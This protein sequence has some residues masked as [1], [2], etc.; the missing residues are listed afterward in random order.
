MVCCRGR[1]AIPKPISLC[2]SDDQLNEWR[3]AVY[4]EARAWREE[5]GAS[6]YINGPADRLVCTLKSLTSQALIF[7]LP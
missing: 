4:V 1:Y 2:Y 7:R 3:K 5:E 6:I